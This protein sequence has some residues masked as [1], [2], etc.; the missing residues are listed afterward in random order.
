MKKAS[1]LL[2]AFAAQSLF[3]IAQDRLDAPGPGYRDMADPRI[4]RE[5][6][7]SMTVLGSGDA[8][9][10]KELGER[11]FKLGLVQ[12][13]IAPPIFAPLQLGDTALQLG[14]RKGAAN[15]YREALHN[16]LQRPLSIDQAVADSFVISSKLF[17]TAQAAAAAGERNLAKGICEDVLAALRT[18]QGT[19]PDWNPEGVA[20]KV[21]VVEE[22]LSTLE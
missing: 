15:A 11:L 4:H 7:D 13:N 20:F 21:K 14:D 9:K 10:L 5:P 12:G 19:A 2:L 3:L 18:Y 1:A 16:S 22:L 8:R 17:Q 6:I